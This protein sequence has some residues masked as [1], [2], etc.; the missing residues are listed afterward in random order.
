VQGDWT[1]RLADGQPAG[2]VTCRESFIWSFKKAFVTAGIEPEDFVALEFDKKA[3]EVRMKTGGPDLFEAIQS[4]EDSSAGDDL[5]GKEV[6]V[7][8]ADADVITHD[9]LTG[10]DKKWYP[11][12]TAPVEQDLEV[13][14]EDSFGRYVLLFPCRFLP[15]G[16]GWINSWLETPL[17][18]VPVDWRPWDEASIRL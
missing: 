18:A 4:E 5:E 15:G 6:D 8:T 12:S 2:N 9:D 7:I 1:V 3:R 14:L 11:I 17:P 16:G 10:A 13:R